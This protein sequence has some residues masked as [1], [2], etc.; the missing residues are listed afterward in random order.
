META[1]LLLQLRR[2]PKGEARLDVL[3]ERLLAWLSVPG[4]PKEWDSFMGE[5]PIWDEAG[6]DRA[7]A[8]ESFKRTALLLTLGNNQA[9]EVSVIIVI[10][11]FYY[12]YSIYH[13]HYYYYYYYY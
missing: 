8:L 10:I 13:Y 7:K 1:D 12:Q 5:G 3:A 11:I 2:G 4:A 9:D 6:I